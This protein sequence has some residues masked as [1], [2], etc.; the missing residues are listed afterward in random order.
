MTTDTQKT[1][2]QGHV[3]EDSP[4]TQD[5]HMPIYNQTT[6]DQGNFQ[7][8]GVSDSQDLNVAHPKGNTK[9]QEAHISPIEITNNK[10]Y[11]EDIQE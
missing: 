3:Q 2:D 5:A 1:N 10:R 6:N 4:E 9:L 11:K 8:D 7:E